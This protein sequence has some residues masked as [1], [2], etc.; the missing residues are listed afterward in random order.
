MR[1]LL[2]YLR[3]AFSALCGLACLL[4]IALWVRSFSWWDDAIVRISSTA[5]H[6]ISAEGRIVIFIQRTTLS[7]LFISFSDPLS[8]HQSP[9]G[10]ERHPWFGVYGWRTRNTGGSG[11]AVKV[12]HCVLVMVAGAL[13]IIPW[14]PLKFSLRSVLIATTATAVVFGLMVWADTLGNHAE[15]RAHHHQLDT[16]Q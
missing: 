8:L 13:A 3:I 14:C 9:E 16:E 7:T 15:K 2:P 11:I 4:S 10:G 12:A 1:K 5:V 6:L